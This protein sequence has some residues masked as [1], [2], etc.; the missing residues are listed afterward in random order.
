MTKKSDEEKL[1]QLD[2]HYAQSKLQWGP[3]QAINAAV[4]EPKFE[5]D[6]NE[7]D[8]NNEAD[9]GSKDDDLVTY[10]DKSC[11]DHETLADTEEIKFEDSGDDDI[12]L[13]DSESLQLRIKQL[14]ASLL[15]IEQTSEWR[16]LKEHFC[17]PVLKGKNCIYKSLVVSLTERHVTFDHSLEHCLLTINS[18]KHQRTDSKLNWISSTNGSSSSSS[19]KSNTMYDHTKFPM[20]IFQCL[21][22]KVSS[23]I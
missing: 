13:Y 1:V 15:Q 10:A 2:Q 17:T 8:S 16:F 9:N 6:E 3:K 22:L 4:N 20:S 12:S 19:S 18:G 14:S 23:K 11:H 5:R 7:E 21:W